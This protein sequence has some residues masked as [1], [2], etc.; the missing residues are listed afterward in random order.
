MNSLVY[1]NSFKL[2]E[3]P[4]DETLQ[5]WCSVFRER[6]QKLSSPNPR[7]SII[8]PAYNEEMY[9]PVMLGALSRLQTTQPIEFI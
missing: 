5:D 3:S 7:A 2:L 9:L 1:S 4:T 6:I 8:V